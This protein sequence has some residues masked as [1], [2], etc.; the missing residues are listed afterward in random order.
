V[1]ASRWALAAVALL[2]AGLTAGPAVAPSARA[3]GVSARAR[4]LAAAY[5]AHNGAPAEA[6]EDAGA[7]PPSGRDTCVRATPEALAAAEAGLLLVQASVRPDVQPFLALMGEMPDGAWGLWFTAPATMAPSSAPILATICATGGLEIRAEP[8]ADAAVV[9]DL[10]EGRIAALDRFVLT[11]PGSWRPDGAQT[12]GEGWFRL[13]DQGG[14]I[15][16][17]FLVV[18][19]GDCGAALER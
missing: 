6:C 15:P 7:T 1:V 2:L 8:S 19:G 13:A 14:W 16:G 9:G 18:A 3:A 4:A 10:A 17:Q 5:A 11:R 12:R